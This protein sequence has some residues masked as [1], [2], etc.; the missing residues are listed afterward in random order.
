[1]QM[2]GRKA[3]WEDPAKWV[4]ESFPWVASPQQHEWHSLLR[5]RP[6]DIGFDGYTI[7]QEGS[8]GKQPAQAKPEE[9]PLVS[10]IKYINC[11]YIVLTYEILPC[12]ILFLFPQ[13]NM[14]MRL[15]ETAHCTGTESYDSDSTSNSHQDDTLDSSETF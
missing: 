1:M 6:E 14:L 7:S 4:M 9:D 5:L 15:K 12:N 2:Y 13:M 11:I 10:C 3:A 8:P